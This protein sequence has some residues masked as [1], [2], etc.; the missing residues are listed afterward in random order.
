MATFSQ[1][2]QAE[3]AVNEMLD[4]SGPIVIAGIEFAP[5]R[6]LKELDEIAYDECVAR[7]L[8]AMGAE[9]YIDEDEDESDE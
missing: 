4:E 1:Q 3:Q 6:I 2:R 8:E 5:S 7:E 9:P